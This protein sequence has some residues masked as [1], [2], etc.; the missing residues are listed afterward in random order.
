MFN[1]FKKD[2][3]QKAREL[4]KQSLGDQINQVSPIFEKNNQDLTKALTSAGSARLMWGFLHTISSKYVKDD[5]IKWKIARDTFEELFG[6][7]T[8]AKIIRAIPI[9]EGSIDDGFGPFGKTEFEEGQDAGRYFLESGVQ[10]VA[11]YLEGM[12]SE[13]SLFDLDTTLLDDEINK[14]APLNDEIP[15]PNLT[16][17]PEHR[18]KSA[19]PYYEHV[20][21]N[22]IFLYQEYLDKAFASIDIKNWTHWA[23]SKGYDKERLERDFNSIAKIFD[24][25]FET[26]RIGSNLLFIMIHQYFYA[27][28]LQR[29]IF[30]DTWAE[31]VVCNKERI[32]FFPAGQNV[33]NL[34]DMIYEKK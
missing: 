17:R 2:D 15:V 12:A 33:Q 21:V 1:F 28:P 9:E 8:A 4:C 18:E 32:N 30:K 3:P 26:H 27:D 25:A 6:V 34:L 20:D 7:E 10:L 11:S 24:E 19:D 16:I 22:Q 29:E 14:P 13:N 5:S 31:L 23:R